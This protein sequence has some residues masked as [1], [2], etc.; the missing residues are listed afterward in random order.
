[1]AKTRESRD[2]GTRFGVHSPLGRRLLTTAMFRRG[3]PNAC[4]QARHDPLAPAGR[5]QYRQVAVG[6]SLGL[7]KGPVTA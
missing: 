4:P 5:C 6:G 7:L 1:M 3:G 2:Q